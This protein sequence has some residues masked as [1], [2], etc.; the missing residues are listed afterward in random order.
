MKLCLDRALDHS[1]CTFD[2][3][4]SINKSCLWRRVFRH[5]QC[6]MLGLQMLKIKWLLSISHGLEGLI[7]LLMSLKKLNH[8]SLQEPT[9]VPGISHEQMQAV[10]NELEY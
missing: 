6:S 4:P 10:I 5:Q 9:D 7:P 3:H 1:E 2:C 8:T